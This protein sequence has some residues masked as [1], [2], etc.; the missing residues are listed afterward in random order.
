MSIDHNIEKYA[1]VSQFNVCKN[2]SYYQSRFSPTGIFLAFLCAQHIYYTM[3]GKTQPKTA[4]ETE[5]QAFQS[6]SLLEL[7]FLREQLR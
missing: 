2:A 5:Q 6:Y 7:L 3:G 1:A 4:F